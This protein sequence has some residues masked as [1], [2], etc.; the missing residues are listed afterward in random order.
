MSNDKKEYDASKDHIN[1]LE[2]IIENSKHQG[3]DQN[4]GL[5]S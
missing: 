4:S 3:S 5:V 1:E 2:K